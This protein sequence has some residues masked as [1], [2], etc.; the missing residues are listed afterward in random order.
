VSGTDWLSIAIGAEPRYTLVIKNTTNKTL[1]SLKL[2]NLGAAGTDPQVEMLP[3]GS[4]IAVNATGQWT[5]LAAGKYRWDW[6]KSNNQTG[7]QTGWCSGANLT[8]QVST[9]S[10]WAS[11]RR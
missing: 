6:V 10:S 11:S 7:S 2:Y 8:I 3:A 4:G 5:N 9:P 1:T